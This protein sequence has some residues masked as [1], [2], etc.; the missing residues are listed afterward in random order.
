MRQRIT[1]IRK[2]M[3]AKKLAALLITKPEN[4]RWLSGFTGQD[5]FPLLITQKKKFMFVHD[6]S[7]DQ[8]RDQTQGFT[9]V[10]MSKSKDPKEIISE[11]FKKVR[12]K[13]I[14]FEFS[15]PYAELAM[16]KKCDKNNKR[17]YIATKFLVEDFRMIKDG[18][19][20]RNISKACKLL[21]EAFVF[22]KKILKTNITEKQ[23]A[24]EMEKFMR[25][26]GGDEVAFTFVVG[27]GSNSA[28]GHHEPS[29]RKL[30]AN[31]IVFLD[32]GIKYNGYCSDM[33]RILFFGKPTKKFE[34]IYE[35][36]KR[37]QWEAIKAVKPG[38]RAYEIHNIASN[39][40]ARS[41]KYKL[42]HSV[43]HG[44]GLEIHENPRLGLRKGPESKIKLEPGM[45]FTVEPGIYPR[46]TGG[47][48]IEDD[49]LVTKTGYKLLTKS[50]RDLKAM[51]VRVKK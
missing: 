51:I 8:A 6:A 48:R 28:R 26:R 41:K 31:E 9:L 24:W 47:G 12:G 19:E 23:I 18:G 43:G 39:E 45:V 33:S 49:V 40:I 4:I 25:D 35:I 29:S 11:T 2:A 32:Y 15:V 1:K 37:S 16:F 14:G 7:I 38:M 22:T 30:K 10:N 42:D 44:M 13:R 5:H 46:N 3:R 20:I 36:I 27:F 21:D 17:H 34:E 50:P